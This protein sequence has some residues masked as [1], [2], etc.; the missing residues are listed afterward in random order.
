[1]NIILSVIRIWV[2]L[3]VRVPRYYV[4][5]REKC[6]KIAMLSYV[7]FWIEKEWGKG[8]SHAFDKVIYDFKNLIDMIMMKKTKFS[9][10]TFQFVIRNFCAKNS[11]CFFNQSTCYDFRCQKSFKTSIFE[12]FVKYLNIEKI[13]MF[14][15][16]PT[17]SEILCR[18]D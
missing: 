8:I 15:N 7:I 4:S 10:V 9:I 5:K 2:V 18:Y 1:M 14:K 3:A 16:K 12:D 6:Q 11:D 17:L 13:S